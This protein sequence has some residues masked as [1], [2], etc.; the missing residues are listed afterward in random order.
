MGV[1][2]GLVGLGAFG[3]EFAPLFTHH[4]LVDRVALCDREADRVAKWAE[5]LAPTG[6]FR[7]GD[8]CDSLEAICEADVDALA[9]ITQPWLHA[10]QAVAAM[11]AGKHVYSAVPVISLPDGGEI[12]DWCDKIVRT[13]ESTGRR[14]MLGET[15]FYRPQTMYCRRRAAEGAFGHFVHAE[16]QYLHDVDSPHCNLRQVQRHRMASKAG[17]EWRQVSQR[18]KQRGVRGGPMHYP[19]HS[20]SGPM[21]VM[22]AHATKVSAFGFRDPGDDPFFGDTF[23]DET[24]LFRMSNG[25]TMQI[26]EYRQIGHVDEEIFRIFGSEASFREDNWVTKEKF[27]K[28]SVDEMRD[29]LPEDVERAYEAAQPGRGYYGGHGGSHVY[30][31]HEF[32]TAIA[33]DRQPAINAWEAAR[34]MAAGV[35]AH[36]SAERDGELLDVPD[37]GDAPGDD[38]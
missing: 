6:K 35:M 26:R 14:Y 5:R 16:G 23:S 24:A 32:V 21:S 30:L 31:V 3:S 27:T 19:T 18:Y 17:E 11:Q 8:A 25:A 7:E 15:T 33:E 29:P 12:L 37:W 36:K 34:Y 10:P 20:V 13:C 4:P 28:L 2:I 9:I 38:A 22:R 1:S